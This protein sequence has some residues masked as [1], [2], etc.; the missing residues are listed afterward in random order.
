[1][2]SNKVQSLLPILALAVIFISF[3]VYFSYIIKFHPEKKVVKTLFIGKNIVIALLLLAAIT[4]VYFI[5]IN[6]YKTYL[7]VTETINNINEVRMLKTFVKNL[8]VQRVL[9]SIIIT[10]LTESDFELKVSLY[11]LSGE[12][13]KSLSFRLPGKEFYIDF[14]ILNFDYLFIEQGANNLAI[15]AVLFSDTIAYA[16]GFELIDE[17][18]LKNYLTA[19]NKYIY[20]LN[21]K[22]IDAAYNFIKK[23][24]NDPVFAKNKGVRSIIG[25]AL[26]H[27][28][29]RGE[30]YKVFLQNTG[31]INLVTEEF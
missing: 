1:M 31:G 14:T 20:G 21:D 13:F 28:A 17:S 6:I 24:I 11:T 29:H 23:A 18:E 10:D 4:V 30:V 9:A 5:S 7:T 12:L 22:D 15:P 16:D 25:S 3:Y 19:D 26:H 8:S 2:F 27:S